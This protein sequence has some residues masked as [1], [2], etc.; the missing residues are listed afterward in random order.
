MDRDIPDII[1]ERLA[2]GE[3][4][5]KERD[6][7]LAR[8]DIRKRLV[9]LEESNG[10]IL[11]AYPV[12]QMA[13]LISER[14]GKSGGGSE[15]FEKTSGHNDGS[16]PADK[17]RVIPFRRFPLSPRVIGLAAAFLIVLGVIPLVLQ[18][19]ESADAHI[20]ETVRVKGLKPSIMI[21]RE[22]DGKAELLSDGAEVRD[23][24]LLQI[25]YIA[26]GDSHGVILSIDGRGTTT[27]H[28]PTS[29][30]ST[31]EL[32]R[33]G[34]VMLPYAYELDDAP[35]FERF[36]FITSD[37]PLSVSQILDSARRLAGQKDRALKG[38]MPLPGGIDQ[39]SIVLQ[40]D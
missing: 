1:V 16:R 35:G 39:Y 26:A 5:G 30:A 22:R 10:K 13:A 11:A 18:Q 9:E 40:K 7:L 32:E 15:R 14:T 33:S 25:G 36:F 19:R 17:P 4:A 6:S 20:S 12:E 27:L 23:R 2:L 29:P 8:E 28:F 31:T 34:Q 37:S 38:S 3:I 24:D 21:Y